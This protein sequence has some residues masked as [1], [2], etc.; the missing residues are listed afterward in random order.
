M[1]AFF[2]EAD[3]RIVAAAVDRL[4]PPDDL[5]CP[6]AAAAGA[7]DYIDTFLGAFAFD[8]PR[9]FA[10]GPFSGRWG[11]D[12]SFHNWMT[13]G[14][15]QELA[16]RMRIE[17]SN[18]MDERE[19]NGPVVGLQE[20]YREGLAAIGADFADVGGDEQDAR[21]AAVPAFKSLLYQHAC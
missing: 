15:M 14:R 17:G 9:I 5:G 21:L 19:F 11:G 6:G 20:Q 3:M 13:L 4:I 16:W 7:A 10:G 8:P 2:G 12:A 18:G 1:T